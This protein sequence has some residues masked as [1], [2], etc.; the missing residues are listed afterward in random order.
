M[1]EYEENVL[2]FKLLEACEDKLNN[3]MEINMNI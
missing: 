2:D 1:F 3:E